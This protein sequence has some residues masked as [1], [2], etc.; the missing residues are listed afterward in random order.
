MDVGARQEFWETMRADAALGRTIVFATHYLAEAD[1]FAERTVLMA[2]GRIV[3]DGR[4][5]PTSGRRTAG[6]R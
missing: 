6:A 3:H 1:E 5:R 4:D 2:R